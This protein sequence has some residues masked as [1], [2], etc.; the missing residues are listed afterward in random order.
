[1]TD[2]NAYTVHELNIILSDFVG[3]FTPEPISVTGTLTSWNRS[4]AWQRG[5]LVT[6]ENNA[7]AAKL[8]VGCTARQGI[9]ISRAIAKT[10]TTL[11][12][13]IDVTMTGRL[14]FHEQYG[15]RFHIEQIDPG[16]IDTAATQI[17]KDELSALLT[18]QGLFDRQQRLPTPVTIKRI[19]LITPESGD[20]GRQDALDILIPLNCEINEL[21]I[22][23]ANTNA[24]NAIARSIS[25]LESRSDIIAIV[26][27]GGASSDLHVWNHETV[28]HAIALCRAPVI[29]GV[30]HATDDHIARQVAWHGA[31]TP[32][33]A[34]QQIA[35]L[36]TPAP[37]LTTVPGPLPVAAEPLPIVVRPRMLTKAQKRRRRI[38][39]GGVVLLVAFVIA[40]AYWLGGRS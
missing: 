18:E 36:V 16:S 33:A 30:G 1:M 13:P 12:P 21:R 31:N 4:K 11:T 27:G 8:T 38:L 28:A 3:N 10:G 24:P 25:S 39:A 29:V 14:E 2:S 6:H 22:P 15:L 5:E 20:A 34:A 32:T 19:G 26:R 17:A 23:T 37:P 9:G 7:V 35:N 40:L